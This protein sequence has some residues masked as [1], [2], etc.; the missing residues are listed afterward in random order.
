FG[1]P[2]G[3]GGFGPPGGPGGMMMGREQKLVEKFDQDGDQ[4][5][6]KTER[7]E[8]RKWLAEEKAAGRGPRGPR[9]GNDNLEPPKPG[10]KV[11]PADVKNHPDAK[12]YDP[13]VVRTLFFTFESA[14][15]EQE[16]ADFNNT[17]VEIPATLMV[18]GKKYEDVGVHFRGAS[19]F[20]TVTAGYKRS[21]NVTLDWVRDGQDIDGYNTFNLLNS[22]TDPSF[23]R[24]VLYYHIA[25]QYIPTPR[26][27]LVR[28]VING[29][30]WGVYPNA[31]QFDKDLIKDWFGTKDGA[32]WKT[33]G[34][35]RGQ[36]TLAYLGDDPEA[37]KGIYSIKSKDK[38]ESW[39]ALIQLT[40]VLNET[41]KEQLV[42][43]LEP[44]LDIDG[45]LKFLALENALINNDGYWVRTSDY[46]LYLDVNGRFHI[47]PHDANET[48]RPGGGRGGPGG[49]GGAGG[50][51]ALDPLLG[52]GEASKPL[53]SKLLAVPELKKRYLGYVKDIAE[54]WLD[55][56]KLGPL[57]RKYHDLIDPLVKIDTR[58]LDSYEAFRKSLDGE[59][60]ARGMR[61]RERGVSL[62]AFADQRRE[63]LLN[64][65]AIKEL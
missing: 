8:A 44:I 38:P 57:A 1:G 17:D 41:S 5:L 11:S 21:L 6:N 19:S 26:A 10:V 23:L 43:K 18:D 62:K 42:E 35:P 55:W 12:F 37:Y 25:S 48:F 54:N 16:M 31:Q 34:S 32:R 49:G 20:S 36:A 61:G 51:F 53:I 14:D 58:N 45:A 15:W 29:E 50:G 4:R 64:L 3:P 40:R 52:E 47:I 63:Y 60:E 7:D 39:A 56:E 46:N 28:V 27:N 30:D 59:F 9:S 24:T 33:P 22:H 2:G 65:P 13:N